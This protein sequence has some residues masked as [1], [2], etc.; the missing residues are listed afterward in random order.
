MKQTGRMT[1][2]VVEYYNNYDEQTR[3]SGNWG[4]IEFVRTQNIICRYLKH[5]PAVV[6]DVGG[7]AGRYS[8]WLAQCGYEVYLIDPVPLHIQQAKAASDAQHERPIAGCRIGDARQ[9]EF[10]DATAEPDR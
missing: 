8:C 1:S 7:A 5:P 4:Q 9:L 6:L 2:K 3:L 10:E